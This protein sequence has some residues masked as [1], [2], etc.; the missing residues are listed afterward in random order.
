MSDA[1]AAQEPRLL[2]SRAA[3]P[4][5]ARLLKSRPNSP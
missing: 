4:Q 3:V 2:F 5:V 1:P